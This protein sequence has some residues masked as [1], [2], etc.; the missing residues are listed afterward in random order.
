MRI[1]S[2]LV[3]ATGLLVSASAWADPV[4]P[5]KMAYVGNWQGKD[6]QLSLSK[7]GKVTYKRD[8]PGKKIDLN[9]DLQGFKGDKFD[10]GVGFVRST[11]VVGKAPHREGGKWK[12]TVDG[13]ELTRDE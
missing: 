11:F 1:V 6:M 5:D 8:Q 13:V 2:S 3:L 10:V 9:L 12:M 7:E 4:P